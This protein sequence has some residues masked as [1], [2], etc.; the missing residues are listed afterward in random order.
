MR[1][2]LLGKE[3]AVVQLSAATGLWD[4]MQDCISQYPN[5]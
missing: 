2:K 3:A 1:V 4:E 5:G